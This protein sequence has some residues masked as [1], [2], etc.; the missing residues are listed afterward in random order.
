MAAPYLCVDKHFDARQRRAMSHTPKSEQLSI[1]V[2]PAIRERLA[3]EAAVDRRP[4]SAFARL[5]IVDAL[6]NREQQNHGQAA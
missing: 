2:D 3:R 6:R 5:L 1:R 4:L